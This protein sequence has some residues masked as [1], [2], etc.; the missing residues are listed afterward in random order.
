MRVWSFVQQKGGSGKSCI[1]TNL[2]VCAEEHGEMVLIV[3]LDPQASATLWHN[4]R[5]NNEPLVL[6][7]IPDKLAD[8]LQSAGQLGVTLCLIDA[9]SKL[10]GIAMSAIRAADLIIC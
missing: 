4:Q 8:V 6:D 9:P 1:C 5:G 10:D 3:D 7:A 2:A